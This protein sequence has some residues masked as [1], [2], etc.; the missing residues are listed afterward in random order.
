MARKS[1]ISYEQVA[2]IADTITTQGERPTV[3]SV[4]AELG[5][6]NAGTVAKHL[7]EW[8]AEQV[9][10]NKAVCNTL[11]PSIARVISTQIAK[12]VQEA[13]VYIAT[14]L[15]DSHAETDILIAEIE[16]QDADLD[17][18]AAEFVT[19]KEQHLAL[20]GRT[21]QL[22]ADA[23]RNTAM[24]ITERAA[25][26][27]ARVELAKAELRLEAVPRIEAEVEKLRTEALEVRTQAANLHEIAAVA[28]AKLEAEV[29]HCKR[30]ESQLEEV[31]RQCKEASNRAKVSAEALSNER[32]G[33]F[34]N[35][36]LS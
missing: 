17:L 29:L 24:L 20:I 35:Y 23:T 7:R 16:R 10:Q 1:T 13:T 30:T 32:V 19:L 28:T 27:S 2:A 22:A 4:R 26:E 25:T 6:G 18:Q 5:T 15:A 31:G 3:V 34:I 14:Q 9:K 21:Q 33:Q 8:A 36:R 11:D 12:S